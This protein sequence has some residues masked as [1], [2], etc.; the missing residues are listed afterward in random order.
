MWCDWGINN[1]HG[2]RHQ[3][4]TTFR[5]F[6]GHFGERGPPSYMVRRAA[7]TTIERHKAK[8]DTLAF[9]VWRTNRTYVVQPARAHGRNCNSTI[10]SSNWL[11]FILT[12]LYHFNCDTWHRSNPIE[13]I[14]LSAY[15]LIFSLFIFVSLLFALNWHTTFYTRGCCK[16]FSKLPKDT[17]IHYIWSRIRAIE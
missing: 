11:T 16:A 12:D 9:G 1:D 6:S 13:C 5:W 10:V 14:W 4:P 8:H 2:H 7:A 17:S 3:H 15:I